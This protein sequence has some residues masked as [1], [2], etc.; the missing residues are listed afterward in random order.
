MRARQVQG[1]WQQG[2]VRTFGCLSKIKQ[3]NPSEQTASG[4]SCTNTGQAKAER[5]AGEAGIEGGKEKERGRER[6]R[7]EEGNCWA[8]PGLLLLL[9]LV[10]YKFTFNLVNVLLVSHAVTKEATAT[11][12]SMHVHVH[13]HVHVRVHV[14]GPHPAAALAVL[15]VKETNACR[16]WMMQ[17]SGCHM[18]L[19]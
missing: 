18:D 8:C 14:T 5:R 6:E 4:G 15:C 10:R 12:M 7:A 3:T 13:V 2:Q 9:R 17:L 1:A 19:A 16:R 11:C